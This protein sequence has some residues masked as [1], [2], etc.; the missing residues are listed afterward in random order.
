EAVVRGWLA[1]AR[2][3]VWAEGSRERR[4]VAVHEASRSARCGMNVLSATR[5]QTVADSRVEGT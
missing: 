1:G 4:Q 3:P 5:E 2:Q